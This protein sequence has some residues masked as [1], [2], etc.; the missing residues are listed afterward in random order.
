MTPHFYFGTIYIQGRSEGMYK[1]KDMSVAETMSVYGC[2]NITTISLLTA[3]IGSK[4]KA[5]RLFQ[6]MVSSTHGTM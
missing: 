2:D 4:E 3:I 1:E 5:K 6:R